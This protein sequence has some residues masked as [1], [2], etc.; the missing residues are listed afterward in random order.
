[1]VFVTIIGVSVVTVRA[2]VDPSAADTRATASALEQAT[3]PTL[4]LPDANSRRSAERR[5]REPAIPDG[6][7]GRFTTAE[8]TSE[9]AGTGQL[10]TYRVE[11]EQGLPYEANAFADNVYE[12]LADK[13]GWRKLGT[14]A[15]QRRERATLRI[16]LASPR[17]VD[18]L[19]APL[20]TRGE[21]SC[22]KGDVVAINAR[23]WAEGAETY[24]DDLDAYRT[25]VINHEIGHSLGFAHLPCPASGRQAPVMLQQTLRLDG[26]E[27][28]PWP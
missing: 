5:I 21:L 28:N 27:K 22:R 9:R 4:V 2:A 26:C 19:C 17:K 6:A 12:T 10:V 13:R 18:R 20:K 23:R 7:S 25:Y 3:L 11:V 1:M 15:F 16:V 8:G 24:P 14:Y